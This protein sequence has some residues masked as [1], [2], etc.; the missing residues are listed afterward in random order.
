MYE[1]NLSEPIGLLVEKTSTKERVVSGILSEV[2]KL[3][4]K[5]PLKVIEGHR[6]QRGSIWRTQFW[7]SRPLQFSYRFRDTAT[8][9]SKIAQFSHHIHIPHVFEASLEGGG[10]YPSE[11]RNSDPIPSCEKTGIAGAIRR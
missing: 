4:V 8:Y 2:V 6:R 11:F 3:L 7:N 10:G 5:W 9:R 1:R